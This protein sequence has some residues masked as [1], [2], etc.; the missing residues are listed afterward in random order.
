[1]SAATDASAAAVPVLAMDDLLEQ[2]ALRTPAELAKVMKAAASLFEKAAKAAA[3]PSRRAP[4]K[5]ASVKSDA[6]SGAK[7]G[8]QLEVHRAWVKYV[9]DDA[10]TNGWKPF[11][12]TESKK[13]KLTGETAT[14]TLDLTGSALVDGQHVFTDSKKAMI[15]RYAMTLSKLYWSVKEATGLRHDLYQAFKAQYVPSS[16]TEATATEAETEAETDAEVAP[17]AA[18]SPA[19]APKKRVTKAS[20]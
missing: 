8:K 10:K 17:S 3:K 12:V 2:L 18:A 4:K 9:Q 13:D 6:S 16:D 1:M 11:S 14:K 19:P 7:R 5:T 20:K 15:P